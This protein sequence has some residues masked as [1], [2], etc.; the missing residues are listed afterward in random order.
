MK[1][2]AAIPVLRHPNQEVD[3]T[4]AVLLAAGR[5]WAVGI[6]LDV[7]RFAGLNRMLLR[8]PG[9]PFRREHHWIEPGEGRVAAATAPA[10][11]AAAAST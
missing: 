10:R 1:P 9:Y 7:A 6:D 8:L 11:S 2:L 3:D 4:A 5:A